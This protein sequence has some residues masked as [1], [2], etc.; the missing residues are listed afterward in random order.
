[1]SIFNDIKTFVSFRSYLKQS[2]DLY[3]SNNIMTKMFDYFK[4]RWSYPV[5]RGTYEWIDSYMKSARMDDIHLIARDVASTNF[6]LYKKKDWIENE[7]RAKPITEHE[8]YDLME[9]PNPSREF[10]VSIRS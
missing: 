3:G 10:G 5:R 6:K 8:C 2:S 7:Y 4:Q 9:T 1:M